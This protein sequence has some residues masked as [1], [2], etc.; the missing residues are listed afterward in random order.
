MKDLP[1]YVKWQQNKRRYKSEA[2]VEEYFDFFHYFCL[3]FS[4]IILQLPIGAPK[5]D[6]L[7]DSL[8][9]GWIFGA[10]MFWEYVTF[11]L[12]ELLCD[13]LYCFQAPQ[14]LS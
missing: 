4:A 7:A 13:Q 2:H 11:I 14:C 6:V 8:W 1:V 9:C 5:I 10:D 3:P 12:P